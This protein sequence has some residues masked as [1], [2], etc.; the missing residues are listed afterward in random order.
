MEQP[1]AIEPAGKA[2]YQL[3]SA[4]ERPHAPI[5]TQVRRPGERGGSLRQDYSQDIG[6]V[7]DRHPDH[8]FGSGRR[9]RQSDGNSSPGAVDRC[10][11]DRRSLAVAKL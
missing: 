11:L 4:K 2:C 7:R 1:A 8:G 9:E 5:Q 10:S 3:I 6:S